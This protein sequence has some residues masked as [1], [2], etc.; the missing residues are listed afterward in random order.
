MKRH[1]LKDLTDMISDVVCARS[2]KNCNF[3]MVLLP[4]SLLTAVPQTRDL[5]FEIE[6]ILCSGNLSRDSY[7]VVDIQSR[8]KRWSGTVFATLPPELQEELCFNVTSDTLHPKIDLANVSTEWLISTLVTVELDR[9]RRLGLFDGPSF[10]ACAHALAYQARSCMPTNFDCDLAYTLGLSAAVLVDARKTGLLVH[11]SNLENSVS[12]W[13][14]SGIPF[15]SLM[16]TKEDDCEVF[17][18]FGLQPSG[19]LTL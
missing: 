12:D 10:D 14:V 9:R 11:A 3:G 6:D 4:D 8:L 15:A 17:G 5:I 7:S 1:S 2:R 16:N 13:R 19:P 18:A